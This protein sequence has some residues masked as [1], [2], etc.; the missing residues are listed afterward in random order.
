M[1]LGL[2][3]GQNVG[4]RDFSHSL[5]LLPLGASVFHKHMSCFLNKVIWILFFWRRQ[6]MCHEMH[7]K[8]TPVQKFPRF[9]YLYLDRTFEIIISTFSNNLF[10]FHCAYIIAGMEKYLMSHISESGYALPV[11]NINLSHDSWI[12]RDTS[13]DFIHVFGMHAPFTKLFQMAQQVNRFVIL[14]ANNSDT[15]LEQK[16]VVLFLQLCWQLDKLYLTNICSYL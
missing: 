12:V 9:Q 3:Q 13:I 6:Y 11:F 14:T 5:T 16:K 8:I 7:K 2:G 4:L 15:R 10:Q 1:P